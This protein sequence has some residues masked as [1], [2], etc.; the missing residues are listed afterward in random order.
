MYC[1]PPPE[2]GSVYVSGDGA[3]VARQ[4]GVIWELASYLP[5]MEISPWGGKYVK[6]KMFVHA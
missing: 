1:G 6:I 4:L 2:S 5:P 3:F